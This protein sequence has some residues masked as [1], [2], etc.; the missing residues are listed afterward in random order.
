L[1]HTANRTILL[2]ALACVSVRA[3]VR[4]SILGLSWASSPLVVCLMLCSCVSVCASLRCAL[5]CGG[6]DGGGWCVVCTL[7]PW[8]DPWWPPGMPRTPGAL[9]G[10]RCLCWMPLGMSLCPYPNSNSWSPAILSPLRE[11]HMKHAV[12]TLDGSC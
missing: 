5:V 8:P 12:A 1:L 7:G 9:A 2:S 10:P 11:L 4:V 3:S 6:C